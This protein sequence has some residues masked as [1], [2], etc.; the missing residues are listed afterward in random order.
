MLKIFLISY[1]FHHYS[2]SLSVRSKAILENPAGLAYTSGF[3]FLYNLKEEKNKYFAKENYYH[4]FALSLGNIGF[5]F[6]LTPEKRIYSL[7]SGIPIGEKFSIGYS[8][9]REGKISLNRIGLMIRPFSFLSLG[10]KIDF[11]KDKTEYLLGLGLKPFTNRITVS[12]DLKIKGDTINSY[13]FTAGIEPI[14]G[15]IFN[16]NVET[17]S[18]FYKEDT[19]YFFGIEFSFGRGI[20]SYSMDKNTEIK[21]YSA[22][23]SKEIYPELFKIKDKWLE[24]RLKGEYP[25]EREFEGFLKFKLKPSFYDL[26]KIF[27]KV[28]RDNKIEGIILYFDNPYFNRAQAEELRKVILKLREKKDIIAYGENLDERN[29]YIASACDKIIIP[30]EGSIF[31]GGPYAERMYFKK[32]FEKT[33]I[34]AQ[35]ERIGEYKSAVEPFIRENMSEEDREQIFLFLKRV[36]EKEIKEISEARKIKEDSL[37]KLMEKEAYFNSEDALKYGLIDTVCFETDLDDV[38]KKFFKK[39]K[40]KK[41][42]YKNWKEEKYIGRD[43]VDTKPKIALLIAE[44]AIVEGES[45]GNP[46]PLIGGKMLGSSTMQRILQKLESDKSIKAVVIRVNS[47]GGSALA[48]EIIWNAIKRVKSKKPI[49]VSMGG[50]AASGGYYISS[51]ANYI[52]ADY[53]TLTGSIGILSGKLA[54]EGMFE[55]LGITFDRVKILKHSDALSFIRPWDEEE[56]N[57]VKKELEWGYKNFIK[58][59]ASSR[60]LNE[61]YVDSIGKGRI[62][63]GYDGKDIKIVDEIGGILDAIEKA[64]ELANIKG[65]VRILIYPEKKFFEM[66]YPSDITHKSPLK[67][68]FEESYIYYTPLIWR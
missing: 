7:G 44:G 10:A 54:M 49:I 6:N 64:K 48:S 35:F 28:E 59:V 31:I 67:S 1:F 40:I 65:D 61:S 21:N 32:L 63:S 47:P 11:Y 26:L 57:K 22:I 60:N 29:Y 20:I 46:L 42:S 3:E 9:K 18:E 2:T 53:T 55:K 25:E 8:Y 4:T 62:W 56:I 12:G 50:I 36:L 19:R 27:E 41:I 52:F 23:F 43:F 38:L 15:I 58:R 5:L 14:S 45:G 37:L 34:I 66:F 16:F 51:P 68:L 13:L 33:G 24:I 17:G 30:N 39:K